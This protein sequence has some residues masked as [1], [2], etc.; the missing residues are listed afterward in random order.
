ML[1]LGSVELE[2]K[3]RGWLHLWHVEQDGADCL[4]AHHLTSILYDHG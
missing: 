2:W 1:T 4:V 3:K